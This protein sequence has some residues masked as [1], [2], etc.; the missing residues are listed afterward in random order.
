MANVMLVGAFGQGNPGDEALCAAFVESLRDHDVVV[1]SGDPAGTSRL[2]AVRAIPNSPWSTARELRRID[3][4]VV[5]GGTVFKSLH[6]SSGRRPNALLRNA[7]ALVAGARATGTKVAMVGVGAG[8]LRGRSAKA[9]V[10]WL[11]RHT[12]LV[13][14]RDEESAALLADAGVPAPFWIGADPAFT[15]G[16]PIDAIEDRPPSVTVALS[17]LAGDDRLLDDLAGALRPLLDDHEIRLQP[18]QTDRGQRDGVLADRLSCRLGGAARIID[19]PV[20]LADAASTFARD[21][22]VIGLRFHALVAAA[23]AGTRFLA[24]AHEPKLAGLARRFAQVSVPAHASAPVLAAAVQQAAE[25]EPPSTATRS[26]EIAKAGHTL[27]LMRLV[28]DDGKLTEPGR[29]AGLP[30]SAGSGTW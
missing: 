10:R 13:V 30:L 18:W 22:L 20:D 7:A 16:R 29:L 27:D 19:P 1:A 3:T 28:I 9:W 8:E 5:G 6:P 17:H 15:L 14:L 12:D 25:V 2:H 23:Q 24:V 21:R 4:V 26:D 11:V